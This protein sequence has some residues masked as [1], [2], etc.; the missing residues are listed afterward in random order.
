MKVK[1]KQIVVCAG[2]IAILFLSSAADA[3]PFSGRAEKGHRNRQ[4]M[5]DN[6][7]KELE[8]TSEQQKQIRKQRVEQI[9]QR[10]ALREKRRSK[11]L[12][13]KQELEK[14]DFDKGKVY[15]LIAEIESLMGEQ[16]EQ[17]VEA[18]LSMKRILTP[19]Q[20]EKFQQKTKMRKG[21]AAGRQQG[22]RGKS[23]FFQN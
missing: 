18:I 17:R 2:V 10:K 12:E 9:E 7:V 13:L 21:K 1:F 14:K 4:G 16:L 6:L 20:F 8:L 19:E 5:R 23:K 15:A 22:K 3:Y 11:R